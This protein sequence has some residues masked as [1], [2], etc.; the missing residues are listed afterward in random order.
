MFCVLQQ[1]IQVS[2]ELQS[3]N[4]SEVL[5]SGKRLCFYQT[6]FQEENSDFTWQLLNKLLPLLT[7]THNVGMS[8]F[9]GIF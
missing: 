6:Y 9:L 8:I 1:A 5:C 2:K 7:H 4:I 3:I